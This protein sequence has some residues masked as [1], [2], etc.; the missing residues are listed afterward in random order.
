MNFGIANSRKRPVAVIPGD[1]N[2][3]WLSTFCPYAIFPDTKGLF[4]R[5]LSVEVAFQV[6]ESLAVVIGVGFAIVQV[7]QHRS[8]KH[9][10][11]ALVLMH[12]FFPNAL[13][14]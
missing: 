11:A 6:I 14:C 3:V 8:E 12:A 1:A 5:D 2:V 7:R 10:E 9:R 13:F 4:P